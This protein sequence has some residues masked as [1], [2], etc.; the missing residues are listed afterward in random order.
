MNKVFLFLNKYTNIGYVGFAKILEYLNNDILRFFDLK[1]Y[2]FLKMGF[3]YENI[4]KIFNNLK[5]YNYEEELE[6]LNKLDIKM[7]NIFDKNYPYLLK[8]I[9]EPPLMFYYRGLLKEKENNLAIVGARKYSSYGEKVA[10]EFSEYLSDYFSIVSGF[11]IGI[12]SISHNVVVS[13]NNRTIA[14]MGVGLD[15]C[16][17]YNNMELVRKI[18]DNS[19]LL[20]SEFAIESL[21]IRSNFPRRNRIIS[22]LSQGVLVIEA[23]LKSGTSI[24]ARLAL[25]QGR[26]LFV[27]PGSIYS[28][29]SDGANELIKKGAS[30]VTKPEDIIEI[31]NF[32]CEF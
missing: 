2:D 8:R 29:F 13:K 19:G 31:L 15:S 12:D 1:K 20:I 18:L 23:G 25:E 4:E 27:V 10:K 28:E 16:Y 5:K 9:S 14:V 26:D 21:P 17:P 11:A 22:G 3:T 30:F 6:K 32:K 24:T 7:C